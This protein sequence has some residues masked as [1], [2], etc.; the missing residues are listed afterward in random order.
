MFS[1]STATSKLPDFKRVGNDIFVIWD[2]TDRTTDVNV[3]AALSCAKAL[4]VAEV[5]T[6]RGDLG[7]HKKK[8]EKAIAEVEPLNRTMLMTFNNCPDSQSLSF[9]TWNDSAWE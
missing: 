3:K 7:K 8:L 4:C 1:A 2:S 9:I 5:K 6:S